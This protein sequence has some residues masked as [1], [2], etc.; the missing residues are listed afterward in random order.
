MINRFSRSIRVAAA[1]FLIVGLPAWAVRGSAQDKKDPPPDHSKHAV[2]SAPM[3][4]W[5]PRSP[6]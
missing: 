3:D 4:S 2:P 5:R 1:A 6:R